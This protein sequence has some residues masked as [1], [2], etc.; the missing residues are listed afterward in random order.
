MR[1]AKK[2][3]ADKAVTASTTATSSNLRLPERMS[4][5]VCLRAQRQAGTDDTAE[6]IAM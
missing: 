6:L 3:T 4:R 2:P 5:Q 1:S